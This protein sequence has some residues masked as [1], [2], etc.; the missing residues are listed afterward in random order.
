MEL[1][2]I[3]TSPARNVTVL[4]ESPVSRAMH[5]AVAEHL[6]AYD[7]V[8][9][10]QVGYLE[11]PTLPG[12]DIRLQMMGGE[13]CGNASMSAG[14][15]L[16]GRRGI[17]EGETLRFRLEVS[18]A[19]G[20]VDC[21][22]EKRGSQLIGRVEMP[23]PVRVEDAANP[24]PRVDLPGITH[25]IAPISLARE[26]AERDIRALTKAM[27][28]P[29]LGILRY[30]E[31]EDRFEP[32]VYVAATDTAVWEQGCGS[33]SAAIGCLRS[34]RMGQSVSLRLRQPG[35]EICVRARY[36]EGAISGLSIST[37]VRVVARGTA[38][39]D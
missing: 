28:V 13:F 33:G 1:S 15:V 6:L 23:L 26:T 21:E 20:L 22:V 11:K 32:L 34:V 36:A 37:P 35:G 30:D 12:A 27:N 18:G 5:S 31:K 10:E 16:A 39:I 38:Y 9:G 19:Q 14:V 25:L 4:V 17:K 24:F 8:G 2:F 29:A 7:G 3:K